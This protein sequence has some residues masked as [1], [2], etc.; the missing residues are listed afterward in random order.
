MEKEMKKLLL[1]AV[2]V[3]V[4][5]LVTVTVSII[6]L[7]QRSQPQENSVS[8]Y[9]QGRVQPTTDFISNANMPAASEQPDITQINNVSSVVPI[10]DSYNGENLTIQIPLPTTTP[11]SNTPTPTS[12]APIRVAST[13]APA[14]APSSTS[15]AATPSAAASSSS[16]PAPSTSANTT[17]TIAS[18]TRT[19]ATRTITDYW[20][21]IGAYSAMVR[22]EDVRESL[23]S[24]GLIS[25]IENR[26]IS[27]DNLY[28]VRLG[29][30][31]SEREAN[32]WLAIVQAI[33]G[34]SDS[35]VRQTTRQ[36]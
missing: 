13:A 26:E 14:A 25:I 21:Q 32:H 17:N 9:S 6:I 1:V 20:I 28:R 36:Q 27:G 10:A 3:G 33:D 18:T 31:T 19:A 34:F 8:S 30:Y 11:S 24:K 35:Q 29:P 16:A 2:S 7:T 4:F 22:A 5:L 15:T 23:A 12:T